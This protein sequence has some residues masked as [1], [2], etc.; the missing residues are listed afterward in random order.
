M[1]FCKKNNKPFI[2]ILASPFWSVAMHPEYKHLAIGSGDGKVDKRFFVL[3][4]SE[5]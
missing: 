1:V 2:F 3:A 5:K 4:D